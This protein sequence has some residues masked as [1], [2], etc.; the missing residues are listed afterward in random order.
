M[1]D[2]LIGARRGQR[3]SH[4]QVARMPPLACK[5]L[6]FANQVLETAGA[7][8]EVT[9]EICFGEPLSGNNISPSVRNLRDLVMY[10]VPLLSKMLEQTRI[11]L[12]GLPQS[13]LIP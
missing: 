8:S 10:L 3:P 11:L 5:S 9:A 4:R 2:I 12:L 7:I 6:Y 13:T 1:D